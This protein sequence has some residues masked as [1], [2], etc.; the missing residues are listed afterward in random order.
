MTV[1][2]HELLAPLD[3][4]LPLIQSHGTLYAHAC[5]FDPCACT[6]A[7]EMSVCLCAPVA[8]VSRPTSSLPIAHAVIAQ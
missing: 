2:K 1:C 6:R 7:D 4:H 3:D 5:A 8:Q